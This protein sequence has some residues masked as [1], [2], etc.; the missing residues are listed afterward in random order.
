MLTLDDTVQVQLQKAN[1]KE[2]FKKGTERCEEKQF[3]ARTLSKYYSDSFVRRENNAQRL[4]HFITVLPRLFDW[5]GSENKTP[6]ATLSRD[7][8]EMI[9]CLGRRKIS[10]PSTQ[11]ADQPPKIP[12]GKGVEAI[13]SRAAHPNLPEHMITERITLELSS[14]NETLAAKGSLSFPSAVF[15][16]PKRSVLYEHGVEYFALYRSIA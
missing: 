7:S 9:R 1:Q 10:R 3:R 11:R 12:W 8:S 2:V 16:I 5:R 6:N 14:E 15:L 4:K 13:H